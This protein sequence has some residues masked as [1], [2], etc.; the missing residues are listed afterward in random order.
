MKTLLATVMM[1]LM[2]AAQT[3][4]IPAPTADV[5][6]SS[7]FDANK[8]IG[9]WINP[10]ALFG[11]VFMMAFFWVTYCTLGALAAVQCPKIMLE[12]C[13]DWGKVEKTED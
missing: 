5:E 10:N 8:Q 6:Y 3:S 1:A 2:V 9:Q 12:K 4:P 7:I 13:I 11:I